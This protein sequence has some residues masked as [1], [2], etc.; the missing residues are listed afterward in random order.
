MKLTYV[1]NKST[2]HPTG[3]HHG[4][5]SKIVEKI[6]EKFGNQQ[7]EITVTTSPLE[8]QRPF[9]GQM[10]IKDWVNATFKPNSALGK[11]Y[12]AVTGQEV[13]PGLEIDTDR[14]LL[15]KS[16]LV[17]V[18]HYVKQDGQTSMR[19]REWLPLN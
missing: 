15:H 16:A 18:E 14:D 13:L 17:D 5:I 19:I 2:L 11:I 7:F 8:S 9:E 3:P 12:T 4:M 1:E 10:E 6:S